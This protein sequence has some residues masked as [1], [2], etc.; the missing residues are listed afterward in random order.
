[1]YGKNESSIHEVVNNI[2]KIQSSFVEARQTTKITSTVHD[3]VLVKMEKPLNLWIEDMNGKCVRID[4]N[5]LQQRTLSSYK[6]FTK[7]STVGDTKPFTAHK[8]WL[9]ISGIRII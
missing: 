4:T 7:K 8:G 9:H 5:V 1:M 3:K 2:T 6:A